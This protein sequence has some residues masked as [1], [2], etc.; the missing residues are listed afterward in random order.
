MT[1]KLWEERRSNLRALLKSYRLKQGFT[2]EQVS[3]ALNKP[4]SYVSKYESG[5]RKLD[6]V[7][8]IEVIEALNITP[9]ELLFDY[10]DK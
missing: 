6:F 1:N 4:Q 3:I 5:E 2:Q 10:L 7:E 9:N 8:V